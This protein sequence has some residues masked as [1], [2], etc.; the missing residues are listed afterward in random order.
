MSKTNQKPSE[1]WKKWANLFGTMS[2]PSIPSPQEIDFQRQFI[3]QHTSPN[4]EFKVLILGSTPRLRDMV[5]EFE[6]CKVFLC[7]INPEM[8]FA[9]TELLRKASPENETWIKASWLDMPLRDD[10]FDFVL[11]DFTYDNIP[12]EFH[13]QFMSEVHRVLKNGG[14][15]LGRFFLFLDE[16]RPISF[17]KLY[18]GIDGLDNENI[19]GLW[20]VGTFFRSEPVTRVVKV[21]EFVDHLTSLNIDFV[22]KSK[23]VSGTAEYYPFD[24]IW[25]S[26]CLEDFEKLTKKWFKIE[27]S[28]YSVD[29]RMIEGYADSCTV[30]AL[31]KA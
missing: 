15:Y 29:N 7:D 4:K 2:E 6:N 20:S 13:K 22:Q 11:G 25:Y 28:F 30:K 21:Q 8:T 26:Y 10:E 16:H 27:D 18:E 23:E 31:R 14:V 12:F 1:V 19:T 5:S 9:M 3:M 24:K 17:K